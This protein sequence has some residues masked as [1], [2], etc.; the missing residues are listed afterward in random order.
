WL[1]REQADALTGELA[2]QWP[3]YRQPPVDRAVLRLGIYEVASEREAAKRAINEAIDLAKRYGSKDSP[4]FVN[5]LLDK[6]ARKLGKLG[7]G[8]SEPP[9]APAS[10]ESETADADSPAD[11]GPGPGD[12]TAWLDDALRT[13]DRS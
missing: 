5:A 7:P 2:P 13:P 12:E 9:E 3:A 10:P 11:A 1:A 8:S 6:V 4:G